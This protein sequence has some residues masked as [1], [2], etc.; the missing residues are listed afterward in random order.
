MFVRT[1]LIAAAAIVLLSA[2]PG[3]ASA[4][5]GTQVIDRSVYDA[6]P[7]RTVASLRVDGPTSGPLGGAIEV[8][9]RAVDGT[10]PTTFGTCESAWVKAVV[11]GPRS[12]HQRA[13][14]R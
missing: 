9:V 7:E 12:H 2:L 3:S 10:L 13:H 11:T 14:A 1:G 5:S 8:T 6:T 4:A